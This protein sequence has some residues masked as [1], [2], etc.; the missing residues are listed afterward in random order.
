MIYIFTHFKKWVISLKGGCLGDSLPQPT[1]APPNVKAPNKM[2]PICQK[3]LLTG[4]QKKST[5]KRLE[6][7]V[8]KKQKYG[9]SN[10]LLSLIE[11]NY[12][13]Y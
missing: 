8:D 4:G 13:L 12:L 11:M 2:K 7:T 3:R 6:E 9:E 10:L 5:P 1:T